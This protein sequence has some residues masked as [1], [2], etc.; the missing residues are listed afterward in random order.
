M[1]HHVSTIAIVLGSAKKR[2][3][4]SVDINVIANE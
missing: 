4:G 2:D 1:K 3:T